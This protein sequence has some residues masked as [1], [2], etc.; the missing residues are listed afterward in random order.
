MTDTFDIPGSTNATGTAD[1]D[2]IT[3]L[4]A[5]IE[6]LISSLDRVERVVTSEKL[7]ARYTRNIRGKFSLVINPI[8][9]SLQTLRES[10]IGRRLSKTELSEAWEKY[11]SYNQKSRRI[12]SQCLDLL[13]GV[14]L[15]GQQLEENTCDIAEAL[16][17]EI[18]RKTGYS[19]TSV[20]I[21]SEDRLFDDVTYRTEIVRLRFPEWDIWSLPFTVYEVGQLIA[22]NRDR[23]PDDGD[24]FDN[25]MKR[26]RDLIID[27]A[28]DTTDETEKW[29]REF[30]TIRDKYRAKKK[31]S[32]GTTNEKT[33][34]DE[35]EIK[36]FLSRLSQRL[37][38]L[39]ADLFA[40]YFLGPAYI[41]ARLYMRF[42]PDTLILDQAP[43]YTSALR[44]SIMMSTLD[45]M[46]NQS[47]KKDDQFD[48]G[49]FAED[50]KRLQAL[51][52]RTEVPIDFKSE[53][54]RQYARKSEEL[55]EP[56]KKFFELVYGH[57]SRNY[58]IGLPGKDWDRK[59]KEIAS[60]LMN[61]NNP[62]YGKNALAEKKALADLFMLVGTDTP[63]SYVVNA[64]WY[65]R[66]RN[67][68]NAST[69]ETCVREVAPKLIESDLRGGGSTKGNPPPAPKE[70]RT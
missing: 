29:A 68:P 53:D 37:K 39:F 59:M 56:Y 63:L 31:S 22:A 36:E 21:L 18:G 47:K 3:V 38:I 69:L 62:T 5:Q 26:I 1:S 61:C 54:R 28:T 9:N 30:V 4:V 42:M 67:P 58:N 45:Q 13:G 50:L 14:M 57:F 8:R 32:N 66:V 51:W 55:D 44:V 27:T 12:F 10:M 35:E 16:I 65:D 23:I 52:E 49:S 70:R 46:N 7:G 41:Y 11:R 15:R 43:E 24:F 64:A 48:P 2:A 33:I 40:T 20:M 19:W 34:R 25:Q 60:S 6:A 17:G